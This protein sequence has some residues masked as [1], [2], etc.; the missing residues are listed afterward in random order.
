MEIHF[1]DEEKMDVIKK[2]GYIIKEETFDIE[3][4]PY[5][6]NE[7]YEVIEGDRFIIGK[8]KFLIVYKGEDKI[9]YIFDEDSKY[10]SQ[11]DYIFHENLKK[12][13]LHYMN[14]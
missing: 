5:R 13:I 8:E 1:T 2:L 7:K 6:V 14:Q 12:T 11:V 4:I 9:H 3:Q 10:M